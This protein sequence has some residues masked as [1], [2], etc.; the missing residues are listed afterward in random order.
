M[1]VALYCRVS[2]N[3]Q[4]NQNQI[5]ILQDYAQKSKWDYIIFEEKESTRKTRP[6]KYELMQRL[7]RK[8]FDAVC[9]LKL[10]RWARSTIELINEITELQERNINFISIREN[11][12][13]S[14][15]TGKLHFTIICAFAQFE[16]DLIR[17]RTLD[18]LAR[19]RANGRIGG[20]PRKINKNV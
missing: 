11:M 9:V 14:T 1:K 6:I 17:E 12:D 5:L 19:A 3:E 13:F 2:T 10:D 20:R 7:R 16:R 18:G 4:N 15:S 8:E